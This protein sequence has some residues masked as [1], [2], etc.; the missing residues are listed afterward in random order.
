VSTSPVQT[1]MPVNGGLHLSTSSQRIP[2]LD[3]LRGLAISLV[4]I[5][6]YG[7]SGVDLFFVLSGFLIGGILLESKK[8]P[9]YFRTFYMRRV[10]RILPLYY[11]W[12]LLYC[13][14]VLALHFGS[15][16]N[17]LR[18]ADLAIVPRYFLFIQN[19]FYNKEH[20][21]WIWF[22]ATWSLAIEE[23]FYLCAPLLIWK[24]ST[25]QLAKVLA[26]IILCVPILRLMI[27]LF[28]GRYSYLATFSVAAR[29]DAL[30]MGMLAA[31]VWQSQSFR[32][33]LKKHREVT[34]R[35][36]L[37]LSLILAAVLYW[38]ERP[39][40]WV[41][42]TIGYSSL[43]ASYV[44][45]ILFALSYPDSWV[46]LGARIKALRGL[47]TISY[48]VYIIH[49]PVLAGLHKLLLH[50]RPRIDSVPGASVTALALATTFALAALS[51]RFF[52][53]PLVRRGH[54]YTY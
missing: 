37:G 40:S 31:V 7:W 4:L 5:C 48:C 27:F 19:F 29:A 53:K 33:S 14:Y 25:R 22:G 52:E 51:W 44:S 43:A 9:R 39:M 46:A 15:K 11:G 21:E 1:A 12:I 13:L 28:A 10:H 17:V 49:Y 23:Q 42:V 18:L 47:G 32:D 16:E 24:L 20:L 34:R 6:H 54:R 8:S 38:L 30:A 45:L 41:T 36:V 35:V 3:G 50:G 2:E 26:A